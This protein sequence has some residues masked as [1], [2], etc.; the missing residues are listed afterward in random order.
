MYPEWPVAGGYNFEIGFRL[1]SFFSV[2]IHSPYSVM[3]PLFSTFFIALTHVPRDVSEEVQQALLAVGKHAHVGEAY[4]EC[5]DDIVG[6]TCNML[7]PHYLA[8]GAK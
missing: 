4:A 7:S 8:P 5:K 6:E 2:F 1:C 3:L